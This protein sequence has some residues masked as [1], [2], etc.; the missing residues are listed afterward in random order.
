[1]IHEV[2]L[3]TIT[4]PNRKEN[5]RHLGN[6]LSMLLHKSFLR[7][8]LASFLALMVVRSRVLYE[9]RSLMKEVKNV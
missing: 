3:L 4:G 6:S 1:M 5:T 2:D 7:K 8:Q 9:L